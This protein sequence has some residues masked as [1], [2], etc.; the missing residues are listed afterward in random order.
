MPSRVGLGEG[1]RDKALPLSAAPSVG[2][3]LVQTVVPTR[4]AVLER[5]RDPPRSRD[6]GATSPKRRQ[7]GG[8]LPVFTT[9][10]QKG[11]VRLPGFHHDASKGGSSSHRF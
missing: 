4:I 5:E 7:I 6:P 2:R 8:R 9:T 3:V 1:P 11:G 10:R